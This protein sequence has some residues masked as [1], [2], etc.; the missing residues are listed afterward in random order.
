MEREPTVMSLG[1]ASVNWDLNDFVKTAERI[2]NTA[3]R[4]FN[5]EGERNV[6]AS[7]IAVELDMSPGNLYYH[8][9]GKDSIHLALFNQLQRNLVSSLGTSITAPDVLTDPEETPL[10]RSWLLLTVVLEQMLD[11]RY[12]YEN[13]SDL[14]HRF[15]E[16]DRGFR[17]LVKLKRASCEAIAYAL[18]KSEGIDPQRHQP[19]GLVD[20]MTLALTYWLSYDQLIHPGD[21]NEVIVHRGVLQLLSF[22]APYLGDESAAFYRDCERLYGLMID[23]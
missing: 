22:C 6:T 18:L 11:Y 16:I 20:A 13:P 8:F 1:T 19:G 3:R 4:L 23:H 5:T 9:K 7:D 12:L 15:P 14:M 21:R 17:R 10:Q 2:L